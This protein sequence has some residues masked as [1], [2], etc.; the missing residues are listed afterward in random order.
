[1]DHDCLGLVHFPSTLRPPP[2]AADVA[3]ARPS[4]P[5]Q[6]INNGFFGVL[7]VR[8]GSSANSNNSIIRKDDNFNVKI[9]MLTLALSPPPSPP[10]SPPSPP[11]S[12]PLPR[13]LSLPDQISSSPLPSC[14]DVF[15]LHPPP[16]PSAAAVAAVDRV[17]AFVKLKTMIAAYVAPPMPL[18]ACCP[19]FCDTK[20]FTRTQPFSVLNCA[21]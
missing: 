19:A 5:L 13:P 1:M 20:G 15:S 9:P 11:P 16:P 4:T 2:A 8:E 10:P 7:E 6:S 21:C 3:A 14:P 18:L 12:P 17:V